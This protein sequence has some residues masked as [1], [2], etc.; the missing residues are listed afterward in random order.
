MLQY[1]FLMQVNLTFTENRYNLYLYENEVIMKK[2]AL[3][4]CCTVTL[5][6]WAQMGM[7]NNGMGGMG[8]SGM[9]MQPPMSREKTPEQLEKERIESV[10]KT[11]DKLK[12]DLKL[13]E[14]QVIIVQKEFDASSK[15]INAIM[16]KENMAQDEKLSEISAINETAE[17]NV[18]NFLND[19]QKKKF[20]EIILDRQKRMEAMKTRS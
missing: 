17:R 5:T 11:V 1:V 15:K 18:M 7:M 8:R 3:L 6:G 19:E 10:Q 13:D 16:K 9:G 14:L 4:F 2:I 20:K 12:T